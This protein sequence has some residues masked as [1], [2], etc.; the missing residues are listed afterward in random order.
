M[1]A[2]HFKTAL[3]QT[4]G[5]HAN[6]CWFGGMVHSFSRLDFFKVFAVGELHPIAV[7]K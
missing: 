5:H 3:C 7:F 1:T 4:P 2:M 6:G